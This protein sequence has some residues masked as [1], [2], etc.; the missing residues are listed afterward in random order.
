MGEDKSI[1]RP[2]IITLAIIFLALLVTAILLLFKYIPKPASE[3]P[4]ESLINAASNNLRTDYLDDRYIVYE[5]KYQLE[6]SI[7]TKNARQSFEDLKTVVMSDTELDTAPNNSAAIKYTGI[8]DERSI[9]KASSPSNFAYSFDLSVN[10]GRK[11][12]IYVT[13]D[14]SSS[15]YLATLAVRTDDK[16]KAANLFIRAANNSYLDMLKNW[17]NQTLNRTDIKVDLVRKNS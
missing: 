14:T 6:Y 11:Y 1:S 16:S 4:D 15:E 3:A 2:I 5:N 12:R 13:S 10:D 8:H 9:R 7:G 17:A